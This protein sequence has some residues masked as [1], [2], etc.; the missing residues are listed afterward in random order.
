MVS[1]SPSPPALSPGRGWSRWARPGEGGRSGWS[2]SVR[3]GSPHALLLG[4]SVLL[5]GTCFGQTTRTALNEVL[6]RAQE[7]QLNKDFK[8]AAEQY[9]EASKLKPAPEIYEKLGLACFLGNSYP[10]AIQAFSEALRLDPERWASHLF[11]G[12]SLYKIYQF[13]EARPHIQRALQLNPSQNDARYW[14]GL[15]WSALGKYGA[16]IEELWA[17]L[18][19]DSKNVDIFYALTEAYLD[20]STVLSKRVGP[21]SLDQGRRQAL[22]DQAGIKKLVASRGVEPWDQLVREWKEMESRYK[23]V[24]SAPQPA[25]EGLYILTR[26]YGE[27]AQLMA[28]RVWELEP[29]SYRAHQLL[30]EA[31]EGKE[32]YEKALSEYREALRLAPQAPGLH[33]AIGHAYWQM[34]RFDD[35]IPELQKE[36]ALNAY[37]SNANYVLGHVYLYRREVEKAAHHL[38]VAVEAEPDFVEARK[39]WGKALS[40]L[41]DNQKAAQELERAA[42][43]DP[44]DDSIHYI[45]AGV[46]KNMGLQG[47]A[48]KEM[49]IFNQLRHQKHAHDQPPEE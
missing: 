32:D 39:Q 27:L 40:L 4:L 20:F 13:Q 11:L 6:E 34:K 46:Y 36:L 12:I 3:S 28:Q 44:E 33:Y 22:E 10:E 37:H 38:Q 16:A 9:R 47:K 5:A 35:A 21:H 48:Q 14:L 41:H 23:D 8:R 30:G 45:L 1:T 19:H 42:A 17:A 43:A 2:E 18:Q 49:E 24:L 29:E 26:I 25:D 15:T 31:S 7:A